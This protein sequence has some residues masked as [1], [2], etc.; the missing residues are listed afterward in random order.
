[1]APVQEDPSRL[2]GCHP[3]P[4]SPLLLSPP[5]APPCF[6]M[7]TFW[8]RVLTACLLQ[9]EG[10]L[11][12]SESSEGTAAMVC[13][14]FPEEVCI[15]AKEFAPGSIA[16]GGVGRKS[17]TRSPTSPQAP[18]LPC[19]GGSAVRGWS[20]I[21]MVGVVQFYHCKGRRLPSV[22]PYRH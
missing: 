10:F 20:H 5:L 16:E 3:S 2:C 7:K 14:P 15:A 12:E 13:H 9:E 8:L 1:M 6:P 22:C 18:S 19:G 11:Q 17:K 21:Q 4:S